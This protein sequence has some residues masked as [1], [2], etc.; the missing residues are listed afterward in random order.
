MQATG[1]NDGHPEAL[2]HPRATSATWSTLSDATGHVAREVVAL[3]RDARGE[4]TRLAPRKGQA[5]PADQTSRIPALIAASTSGV[6][7]SGAPWCWWLCA[8][9]RLITP[10]AVSSR[11]VSLQVGQLYSSAISTPL[12]SLR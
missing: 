7:D 6:I 8:A 3:F 9:A 10:A 1:W 11:N 2:G 4:R 5:S 12:P